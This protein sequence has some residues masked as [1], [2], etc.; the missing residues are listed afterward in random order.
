M[1]RFG[2][3]SERD[4]QCLRPEA[5]LVL[6]YRPNVAD[7]RQE[8]TL[9]CSPVNRTPDLW[10][11]STIHFHSILFGENKNLIEKQIPDPE[12]EKTLKDLAA[13]L[14][15]WDDNVEAIIFAPDE[16][17]IKMSCKISGGTDAGKGLLDYAGEKMLRAMNINRYTTTELADIHFIYGLANG[18]AVQLYGQ[19]YPTR[20]QPKHQTFTGCIRT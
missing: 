14:H 17:S 16:G 8:S 4:L 19:R 20:R 15:C 10:C 5:S 11:G 2:G 9:P 3:L 13:A 7:E 1:S 6:I 18:Y 12:S